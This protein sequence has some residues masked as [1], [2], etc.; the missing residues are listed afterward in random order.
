ME[1]LAAGVVDASLGIGV[2]IAGVADGVAGVTGSA[3]VAGAAVAD[4]SAVGIGSVTV[5]AGGVVVSADAAGV[6]PDPVVSIVGADPAATPGVETSAGVAGTAGMV[7]SVDIGVA[8]VSVA[9]FG[10]LVLSCTK[11]TSF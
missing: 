4:I 2:S 7:V 8:E 1:S 11:I 5:G 3:G 9:G 10:V 6:V